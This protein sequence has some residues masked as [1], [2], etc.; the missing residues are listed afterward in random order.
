ML[1]A[2][3]DEANSTVVQLKMTLDQSEQERQAV[4]KEAH[5]SAIL[6]EEL[7]GRNLSLEVPSRCWR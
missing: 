7:K 3:L 2:Q 4:G 5:D 6:I 1:T